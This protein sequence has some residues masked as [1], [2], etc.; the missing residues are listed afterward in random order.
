MAQSVKRLT[1]DLGSGH[2][3]T[4]REI[5]THMGLCAVSLEPAWYALSSLSF[6]PPAHTHALSLKIKTINIF[7]K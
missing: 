4:V 6:L 3:F 2:D 7:K 1:S 5:K